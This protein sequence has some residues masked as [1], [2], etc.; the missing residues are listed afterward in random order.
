MWPLSVEG[1]KFTAKGLGPKGLGVSEVT[2]T[3]RSLEPSPWPGG[4]FLPM[5]PKLSEFVV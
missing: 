1:L 4:A 3:M 2:T 5:R